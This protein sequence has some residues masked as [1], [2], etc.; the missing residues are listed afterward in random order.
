MLLPLS[1]LFEFVAKCRKARYLRKERWQSP[2]PVIVVGN[3]SIG[4]TGKTPV[5]GALVRELQQRGYKPGIVSRGF[6]AKHVT[7]PISVTSDSDPSLVG[8]EPVMLACQLQVPLVV[9]SDR[10]QAA[11]YLLQQF[12]CDLIIADDGLQH[13]SLSRDI[14]VLV[15]DGE[16]MLGN[17][18]CLPAGPLREPPERMQTVDVVLINGNAQKPL[19][20]AIQPLNDHSFYLQPDQLMP[21]NPEQQGLVPSNTKVHAVAGIG[22]PERFFTTLS[23]LGYKVVP[24]GYPDHH[25]FVAEDI[26]FDDMLPVLMTAKD[27]VKC[28]AFADRRHWYLPVTTCLPEE[29]LSQIMALIKARTETKFSV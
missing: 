19:P 8:D 26:Q 22:N 23:E 2:V 15:L 5:V 18:L 3:I 6:G 4:G 11:Q 25:A 20:A 28:Q 12:D 9:D 7:Y 17:G 24:H 27:A 13:Y 29:V 1:G 21:V 16:R 10:V 14:E